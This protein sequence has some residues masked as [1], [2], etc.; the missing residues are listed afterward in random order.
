MERILAQGN[1]FCLAIGN[2]ER[3]KYLSDVINKSANAVPLRSGSASHHGQTAR[4]L[5]EI[6]LDA[7]E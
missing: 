5:R 3:I 1:L 4:F 2:L 6:D 7:P